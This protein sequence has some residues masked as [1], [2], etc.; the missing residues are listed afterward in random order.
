MDASPPLQQIIG[1]GKDNPVLTVCRNQD[2]QQLHVYFGFELLEIV[3]GD[4]KD[5]RFK[6]MVAH[7]YNAGVKT[8]TIAKELEIDPKT[9]R[10]WGGALR[11]GDPE[12]LAKALLGKEAQRKYTHEVEAFARMRFPAVYAEDRRRYS[13]RIRAEIK[14][15]FGTELSSETLRPLFNELKAGHSPGNA[16]PASGTA[17]GEGTGEDPGGTKGMGA[18]LPQGAILCSGEGVSADP[19]RK[20]NPGKPAGAQGNHPP[21]PGPRLFHYGGLLLF[22]G[23][24]LE[25]SAALPGQAGLLARQWLAQILLGAV[26][27]EQ[28]KLLNHPDLKTLLGTLQRNLAKQRLGLGDAA[29]TGN[30]AE[31]FKLNA[32]LCGVQ[33]QRDF[34]LDPHTHHYTGLRQL[35]KAWCPGIGLADKAWHG[36]FIHTAQGQPVYVQNNDNFHDL[37]ERFFHLASGFRA[38]VG[39]P[40][41]A[42]LTFVVDRGIYGLDTFR[43]ILAEPGLHLVTWEKGYARDAWPEGR[44]PEGQFTLERPRNH[45]KDIRAYRIQY[46]VEA[47]WEKEPRL[48]RIIIRVSNPAGKVLEASILATD[49][50]RPAEGA[51]RLMVNRW[52]QENDFKYM[53]T[54]FGIGAITSYAADPYSK[55]GGDMEDR[56]VQCAQWKKLHKQRGATQK[57]AARLALAKENAQRK[58]AARQTEIARLEA[59]GEATAQ[60]KQMLGRLRGA[61][62]RYPKQAA[63]RQARIDALLDEADV[64]GTQLATTQQEAS[65]LGQLVA[66]GAEKLRGAKKLFMDALKILARNAFYQT[67][68][69]FKQ[70]YNNYRDDHTVFRCFTQSQG[71]LEEYEDRVVCHLLPGPTYPRATQKKLEKVLELANQADLRFPDGSNRKL[72]LLLASDKGFEIAILKH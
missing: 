8:C 19:N 42:D 69:P 17:P 33:G 54:H 34:Y 66:E 63:G 22:S 48:K 50:D 65:R 64:L 39:L 70:L 71:I 2:T 5:T 46:I 41:D 9:I 4:K 30:T 45:A 21:S 35:L 61:S 51:I 55:L 52:Y 10:K 72:T 7:L 68:E 37:R 32:K 11:S 24:L 43:R 38:T 62:A 26:V 13:S 59:V 3:P 27:I 1:T 23:Y 47:Q 6:L 15:V 56:Q 25:A 57:K 53:E 18:S 44:P 28:S 14:E 60:E 31:L 67:L 20:D 58:Q 16:P 29:D 40:P 12:Q 49:K 36:D